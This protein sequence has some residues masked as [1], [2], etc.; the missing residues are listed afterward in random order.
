[1]KAAL[2]SRADKSPLGR[3][4]WTVDRVLLAAILALMVIG[5]ILVAAASPPVAERI[6]YG[7]FHFVKR[8]LF[9]L[10]PTFIFLIGLSFLDLKNIWRGATILFLGGIGALVLVLLIGDETKG[11]QRW[12][13]VAG[14]SL[15]PSEF[16]KPAFAVVTAWLMARQKEMDGFPGHKIALA[17]FALVLLLLIM[18]P[19][20]GMSAV[21]VAIYGTQIFLAGL[22]YIWVIG[23]AG[24]AIALG[25]TGYFALDHVRS[26]FDRFFN[27]ESGDTYQVSRSLEAF[28]EG[29]LI[30]TGPGQGTVKLYIPDA[31]ADFIFSVA[32]EEM[33]LI[34]VVLL[35][36][37]YGFIFMRGMK[38][39]ADS[40]DI[41]VILATGGLL[42]MFGLQ[43]F[44]H[45]ASSVSLIP[46]KG[47]TLP[48]VS[49]GGSS[50][51][52]MGITM[53]MVLCFTRHRVK[54]SPSKKRTGRRPVKV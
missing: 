20:Y 43:A 52:A 35:I 7:Q 45:M 33:G 10:I 30:G 12:L 13:S 50:M 9:F 5:V 49:Y 18:Q 8:H 39:V 2:F 3:W 40:N 14:F 24:A 48:F 25:I 1:M 47:M 32:G 37:L 23:F 34:F 26:R 44:I 15:Q 21:V 31:H 46:T 38:R 16:V 22:P 17:L 4:W 6:G 19:D 27:P 54:N 51:V 42:V 28:K 36:A 11:A 29:G 41:F 53:G